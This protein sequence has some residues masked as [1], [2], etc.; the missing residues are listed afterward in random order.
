VSWRVVVIAAAVVAFAVA[1]AASR[2][3]TPVPEVTSTAARLPV[4]EVIS[5]PGFGWFATLMV[6]AAANESA[7]AGWIT[8]YLTESGFSPVSATWLLASH[9]LGLCAGRLVFAGRVDRDKRQAITRAAIVAAAVVAVFVGARGSIV[10]ALGPFALGM[11]IAVIMPTA[12][13]FAGERCPGNQGMLFGV[14]LTLGQVGSMGMPALIG[15]VAES[16]GIRWGLS[17]L[18]VNGGVIAFAA[19]RAARTTST[20]GA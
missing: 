3:R 16:A 15:G 19:Q 6:A 18:I 11:A 13:A 4:R 10:L 17:V 20:G 9:W 5:Q 8:T 14:L 1:V 12:L 7:S 2:V